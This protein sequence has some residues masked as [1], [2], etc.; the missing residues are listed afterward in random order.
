MP[1]SYCCIGTWVRMDSCRKKNSLLYLPKYSRPWIALFE[2]SNGKINGVDEK[3][4]KL[5]GMKMY[6]VGSRNG[7]WKTQ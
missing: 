7:K 1:L 2:T 5:S 4:E 3:M 6:K